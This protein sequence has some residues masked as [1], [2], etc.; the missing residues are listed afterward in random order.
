M[1][2]IAKNVLTSMSVLLMIGSGLACVVNGIL[3]WLRYISG[4]EIV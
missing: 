2:E 4:D 3:M 1:K